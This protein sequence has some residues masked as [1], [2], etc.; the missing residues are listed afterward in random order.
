MSREVW[1]DANPDLWNERYIKRQDTL[2][3]IKYAED[4]LELKGE[5]KN[6]GRCCHYVDKEGKRAPCKY[7]VDNKDGTFSCSV[8]GTAQRPIICDEHPLKPTQNP[9]YE[10]NQELP[11]G[12]TIANNSGCGYYWI[13][14]K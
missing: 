12:E 2:D 6:C 7:L 9:Y 14:K 4:N 11:E 5:C 3:Q 13:I 8:Y 10:G 1:L